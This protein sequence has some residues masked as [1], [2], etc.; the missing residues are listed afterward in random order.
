[1]DYLSIY[2]YLLKFLL[3]VSCYFRFFGI[4]FSR[5]IFNKFFCSSYNIFFLVEHEKYNFCLEIALLLF[6]MVLDFE[7]KFLFFLGYLSRVS[8]IVS[9]SVAS[10]L[11]LKLFFIHVGSTVF[12]LSF[13]TLDKKEKKKK[14]L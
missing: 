6:H 4:M 3:L 11:A 10:L 12:S 9:F 13:Y 14:L 2:L 5:D 1:M 7:L 8:K